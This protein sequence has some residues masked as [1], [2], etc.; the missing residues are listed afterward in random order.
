MGFAAVTPV[1]GVGMHWEPHISLWADPWSAQ[2][3][4]AGSPPL[5]REMLQVFPGLAP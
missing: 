2:A 3:H 5:S 4:R 1:Q